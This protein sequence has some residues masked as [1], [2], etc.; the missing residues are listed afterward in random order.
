MKFVTVA[1]PPSVGK[2]AVLIHTVKH[3]L[4][5]DIKVVVAKIDCLETNDGERYGALGIP[6]LKGLSQDICPDHFYA[7]NLEEIFTW[8]HGQN[9]ELT[10]IETAGLC[11]RCA[12]A[13]DGCLAISVVDHL[14]GIDV[15]RKV[16][17]I[18]ST[19]DVVVITKGDVVSQA[20]REVFRHRV[21]LVNPEAAILEVN[22]LTG[23]GTLALKKMMKQ[24]PDIDGVTGRTLRG[25]LP[26]AICSYCTGEREIGAS[27][28]VGHVTKIEVRN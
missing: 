2:T 28:Q 14:S 10:V 13:I 9:A 4:G 27:F 8:A 1:G 15:P 26:S 17:P 3:L 18:L 11:H 23:K 20:E 22:G 19:A 6:V 16:G 25:S 5:D 24:A 21:A 12:P 7:A